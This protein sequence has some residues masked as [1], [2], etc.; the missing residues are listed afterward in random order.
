MNDRQVLQEFFSYCRVEK[1][2]SANTLGAYEND[3]RRLA[4][5]ALKQEKELLTL[6]RADLLTVVRQMKDD[7]LNERSITRFISAV[8]GL[9][10]YLQREGLIKKDPAEHLEARKAWQTLPV[11][12]SLE[13]VNELLAQADVETETGLRDR[14][15]LE[16]MYAT[17]LRV[18]EL[19]M[20]KLADIEWEAGYLNCFGKGSKQRRVPM[21]RSALDW[22]TRY[23]PVRMRLLNGASSH[24]LFVEK[25]GRQV[26]RQKFWKIVTDY[27]R[28]AGLPNVTPHTLRHSFATVLLEHGAD[29]RSVQLMLGHSDISTTQ[30]YTHVTDER[31]RKSYRKFHPRA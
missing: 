23:M 25:G 7:G 6:D 4:E 24:L 14:A 3:L 2:L 8:R 27:A 18:S 9:Y 17:G 16:L 5:F 10:K 1:G 15:M 29:L 11:F 22:L 28:L 26:T 19:V 20:L 21:G 30:I 13:Q 12:L 31:L